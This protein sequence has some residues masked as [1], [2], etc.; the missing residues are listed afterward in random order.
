MK[1]FVFRD[2]FGSN[3]RELNALRDIRIFIVRLYINVWYRFRCTNAVAAP[4]Q[5]LIFMTDLAAYTTTDEAASRS[6]LETFQNHLWYLSPE[7]ITLS[8]FDPEVSLE[9][10][11]NMVKRLRYKVPKVKLVNGRK[12]H[13]PTVLLNLTLGDFVSQKTKYFFSGF[14]LS[15]DFLKFD[16]SIRTWED[17]DAYQKALIFCKNLLVVNDSEE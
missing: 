9:E 12:V 2:Q 10:K 16:P 6:I 3:V 8:A 1:I 4:N 13:D 5:D 7:T 14:C 11:R 17:D 15:S